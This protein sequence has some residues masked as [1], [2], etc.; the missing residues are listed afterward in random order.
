MYIKKISAL[1]VVS[2]PPP[3][4]ITLDVGSVFEISCTA[5]GVPTPEVV[6]RLNWGHT[7]PKCR[8]TS[9]NGVGTLL[10]PDIQIEDQGAYSCEVINIKGTVFAVPDTILMVKQDTVC[11]AGYFNEQAHSESE[12]IKCFC[13][14]QSNKCR[15]ADLFIFQFQPP[16]DTLKLIG[17]R[18]DANTG[19]VE[20]RDEP[21]YRNAMPQLSPIGRNGVYSQLP[22][23]AELTAR[24]L[25][26]YFAMP[27]NYYGNQLK[28]YGGYLRFIVRQ[29]NRGYPTP[30]PTVILTG[31]GYTLL[32]KQVHTLQPNRDERV[33]IRFFAGEWVKRS[34]NYQETF[35]T[36]EEIMMTLANIDNLL[37]KLQYNDGPLNTT[38]SNIEME[39]AAQPNSGL[40][41][42]S[43]VEECECPVGYSGTSCEQCADGFERHR[44]GPWLGQC[45]KLQQEVCPAGTYGDPSRGRP[46]EVCPC[47][48][49]NPSN[50]FA[51]TCSLG[52]DGDV[53]C[54]CP[55]GY[56]GRRCEQCASG[57]TGN[58]LLPGDYC[59]PYTP[60]TCNSDGT[61]LEE[62]GRCKC[63]VSVICYVF[64][65]VN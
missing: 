37:I 18:V 2:K 12:C 55:P 8:T 51:R 27:E 65:Y 4:M 50:Q 39:S 6:W 33:E 5:V 31:N 42:A 1:P 48:L 29:S 21:I 63:K 41:P 58:P 25:V 32:S 44:T 36:R 57:Y 19:A 23:Y 35:A 22:P 49:T 24:E 56:V 45:Q 46:C 34:E 17:V 20:I 60:S 38:L 30:G 11:P 59:R 28:S 64:F 3:P 10:C 15:S 26:P 7:P 53:T 43:Y 40:G 61:S 52:S 13:F 47:P 62:G 14:G 16:F 54:D 9:V